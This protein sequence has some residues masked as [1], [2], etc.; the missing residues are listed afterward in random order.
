MWLQCKKDNPNLSVHIDCVKDFL[1]QLQAP[2]KSFTFNSSKAM[3]QTDVVL[4]AIENYGNIFEAFIHHGIAYFYRSK[5][6][7]DRADSSLVLLC[8]Q[9]PRLKTLVIRER[10]ST[11]TILLIATTGKNLQKLIIRR[12]AVIIRTDWPK[13]H[14]W[15]DEFYQWLKINSRKYE[16]VEREVSQIL[17]YRWKM[18]SDKEFKKL[19]IRPY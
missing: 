12:N 17:G 10:I 13:S 11:A 3:V 9:C 19:Y 4:T 5:S 14:E 18:L 2:V 6:F 7:H 1:W 15:S 8:R 16:F